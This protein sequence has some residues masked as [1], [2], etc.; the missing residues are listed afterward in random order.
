MQRTK[1][2]LLKISRDFVVR[3]S[4]GT[5]SIGKLRCNCSYLSGSQF[6]VLVN[7]VFVLH[8]DDQRTKFSD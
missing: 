8:R 6:L 4:S 5:H 7:T 3:S 2:P 1:V